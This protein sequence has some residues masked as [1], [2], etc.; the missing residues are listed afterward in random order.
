M[1][2]EF[3]GRNKPTVGSSKSSL[4]GVSNKGV[5]KSGETKSRT[6]D[7]VKKY[8]KPNIIDGPFVAYYYW[9]SYSYEKGELKIPK[10]RRRQYVTNEMISSTR[11]I[12]F[13]RDRVRADEL[14]ETGD[15]ES[16]KAEVNS[17]SLMKQKTCL[18]RS[19]SEREDFLDMY[20][21]REV[22]V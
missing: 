3:G 10:I 16:Q 1:P 18:D 14:K 13:L 2:N 4:S 20:P 6:K 19:E 7:V 5:V 11:H 8:G 17:F 9:V 15:P 21:L 12:E 22:K